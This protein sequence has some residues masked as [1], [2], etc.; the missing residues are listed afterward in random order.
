MPGATPRCPGTEWIRLDG[1]WPGAPARPSSPVHWVSDALWRWAGCHPVV[2]QSRTAKKKQMPPNPHFDRSLISMC[3]KDTSGFKKSERK[4]FK[5]TRQQNQNSKNISVS[6]ML[7]KVFGVLKYLGVI[8]V[9]WRAV[10]P[11][12]AADMAPVPVLNIQQNVNLFR[13]KL[14]SSICGECENLHFNQGTL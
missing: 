1:R 12:Y 6:W 8:D 14:L 7:I 3:R 2:Q 4:L 11:L 9:V 10:C 5:V 13:E